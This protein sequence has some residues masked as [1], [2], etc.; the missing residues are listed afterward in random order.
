[1]KKIK[2]ELIS[3]KESSMDEAF[4]KGYVIEAAPHQLAESKRWTINIYIRHDTGDQ[5]NFR[6]FYAANTFETKEE[7]VQYCIDLTKK[8]N[9]SMHM[10]ECHRG[11]DTFPIFLTS[12]LPSN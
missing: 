11:R 7:A 4:Y 9:H 10:N 1:L 12:N 2:S 8:P 5:I 3:E 6:N